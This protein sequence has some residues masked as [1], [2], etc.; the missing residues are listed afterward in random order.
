MPVPHPGTPVTVPLV[1]HALMWPA[2][3][4]WVAVLIRQRHRRHSPWLGLLLLPGCLFV[5]AATFFAAVQWPTSASN[6]FVL[7]LLWLA[8]LF[9]ATAYFALR[10]PRDDEGDDDPEE[11]P[12]P[13]WWPDFEREFRDYSRR[14][15]RK[16]ARPPKAP[17]GAPS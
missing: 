17:A 1:A 2:L 14:G 6:S 11:L 8:V 4:V 5:D 16:P 12:E 15:P 13:P 7:A 9:S 3:V 10:A